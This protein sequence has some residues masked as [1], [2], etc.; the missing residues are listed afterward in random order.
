[1]LGSTSHLAGRVAVDIF[2]RSVLVEILV[3]KIV[4]PE[5]RL[6]GSQA[7]VAIHVTAATP[8]ADPDRPS[9]VLGHSVHALAA[10]LGR[11]GERGHGWLAIRSK[12]KDSRL[13]FAPNYRKRQLKD[14]T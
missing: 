3:L 10:S 2:R 6:G 12:V 11:L 7:Q 1:M 4:C 9:I 8:A 13:S 5:S 14:T